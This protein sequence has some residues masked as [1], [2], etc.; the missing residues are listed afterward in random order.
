MLTA[1]TAAGWIGAMGLFVT[2]VSPTVFSVLTMPDAS[3]F[4]RAYFPRLFKI[5]MAVGA[6]LATLA[7]LSGQWLFVVFGALLSMMASANLWVLTD[8]INQVADA[9]VAAPED[10]ELKKKFATLHGASA[11]LFG[12]GGVLCIWIVTD[13]VWRQIP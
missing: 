10:A 13:T 3:R 4:L 6:L 1:I 12:L 11:A 5:E 9:L 2:T 8:R 7:I